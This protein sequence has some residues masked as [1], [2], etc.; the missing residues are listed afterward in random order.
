MAGKEDI[1]LET[2]PFRG[3]KKN[4]WQCRCIRCREIRSG[5]FDAEKFKL[6]R[7]EYR[8]QTGTEIFLSYEN[9]TD[10]KLA[11]F[12]RLRLPDKTP[13]ARFQDDLAV[14]DGAA[15]VRE[16][17]TYG[18]LVSLNE[19]G[20]QSQHQG[21]GKSLLEEAERIATEKGYR[22]IAVISGI[23]VRDYYRKRGYE[24][25]RTY[26]VKSL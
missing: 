6:S 23:G 21:L 17:H 24:L 2:T 8:T 18:H 1:Q 22:K 25:D 12:L 4:H 16:L 13:D 7:I 9:T 26:M 20:E 5:E 14:L 3:S 19:K 15:L 11:A 10:N